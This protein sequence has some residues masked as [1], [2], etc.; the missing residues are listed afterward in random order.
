MYSCPVSLRFEPC[1]TITRHY[2]VLLRNDHLSLFCKPEQLQTTD[3][4]HVAA[5]TYHMNIT[6]G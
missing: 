2:W 1:L 5:L 6:I 3:A 4:E